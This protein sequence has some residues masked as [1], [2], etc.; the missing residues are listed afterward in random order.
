MTAHR[1]RLACL[2]R[3]AYEPDLT[4][5]ER[6][7]LIRFGAPG[8]DREEVL[9]ILRAAVLARERYDRAESERLIRSLVE[10]DKTATAAPSERTPDG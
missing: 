3:A 8:R 2:T 10:N 1:G 6:E 7:R 9:A 4:S 5:V